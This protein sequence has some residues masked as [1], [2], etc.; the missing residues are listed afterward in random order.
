MFMAAGNR[1]LPY[2]PAAMARLILAF[3]I[4]INVSKSMAKR[5][6]S[7]FYLKLTL[8]PLLVKY[9]VLRTEVG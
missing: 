1:A 9:K 3:D 6:I 4:N 2:H 5:F 8:S 7:R